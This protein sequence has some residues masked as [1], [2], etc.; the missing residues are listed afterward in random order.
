[1]PECALN[2][3]LKCPR[4][5]TARSISQA[6][7]PIHTIAK[8]T[9]MYFATTRTPRIITPVKTTVS[10]VAITICSVLFG[11]S[12]APEFQPATYATAGIMWLSM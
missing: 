8:V 2:A 5:P 6:I 11:E 3:L 9:S 10:M 1:M 4:L 7:M 12:S